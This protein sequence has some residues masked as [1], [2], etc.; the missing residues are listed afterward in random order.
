[1]TLTL[2]SCPDEKNVINKTKNDALVVTGIE[3][4]EISLVSPVFKVQKN[5]NILAKNY[6]YVL[7]FGRF[8]FIQEINLAGAYYELRLE[9]DVLESFWNDFKDITQVISRQ[10]FKFNISLVDSELPLLTDKTYQIK[11]FT[12]TNPFNVKN[13][14]INANNLYCFVLNACNQGSQYI[15]PSREIEERS[16]ED[17]TVEI[18]NNG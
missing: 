1:M 7:E 10:E 4:E 17:G 14:D 9:V 6:C 13:V 18:Q 15:P 11:K 3:K 16:E 5:T 2:Y 8:Y 12:G